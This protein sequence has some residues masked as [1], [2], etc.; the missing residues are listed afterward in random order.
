MVRKKVVL[1]S[2]IEEKLEGIGSRIKKARL[3][4]NISAEL[5]AKHAGISTGT[6]HAIETGSSTVS[7]GAYAAVLGLLEMDN[8]LDRIALD[9]EGIQH[10][11]ESEIYRRKRAS[12]SKRN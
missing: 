2:K 7:I 5:L 12:K 8:D 9:T 11:R 10:F 6:M 3:R 4:R 1:T